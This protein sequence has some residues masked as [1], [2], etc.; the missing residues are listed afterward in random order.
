MAGGP[1]KADHHVVFIRYFRGPSFCYA[2]VVILRSIT[3]TLMAGP[4]NVVRLVVRGSALATGETRTKQVFNVWDFSRPGTS[5]APNKTNIKAAFK[6]AILTPLANC[7]SVSYVKNAI[8]VRFL[9]DY[10]DPYQTF[11][12][13]V[14]GA[15]TGDSAPSINNVLMQMRSTVRGGSYRGSKRFGPIAESHTLLDYLNST[16]IAVWATFQTAYLAGFTDSDGFVWLPTVVSARLSNLYIA[17]PSIKNVAVSST[18]VNVP[19]TKLT[20]R[21]QLHKSMV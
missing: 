10:L 15:V 20:S 12:D 14:N 19:L 18:I 11:V 2:V 17:T 8:D 13:G 5:G 4:H 9:D 21:S 6:T 3:G 1:R 7:L 16:A